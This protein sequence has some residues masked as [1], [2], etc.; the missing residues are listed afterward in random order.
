MPAYCYVK[1]VVLKKLIEL[2]LLWS[3]EVVKS[4]YENQVSS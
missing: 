2:D 4:G 3:L 1:D